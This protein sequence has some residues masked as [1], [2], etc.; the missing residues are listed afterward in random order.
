MADLNPSS[1]KFQAIY[2]TDAKPYASGLALLTD[3]TLVKVF[4]QE[5]NVPGTGSTKF[6]LRISEVEIDDDRGEEGL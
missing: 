4:G 5:V 6:V 3:G 1:I 2:L